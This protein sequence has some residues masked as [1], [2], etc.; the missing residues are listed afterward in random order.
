M[1]LLGQLWAVIV[2]SIVAAVLF[3]FNIRDVYPEWS[4]LYWAMVS[5]TC[6]QGVMTFGAAWFFLGGL[7]NVKPAQR[8]AYILLCIGV[9]AFGLSQAQL[10]FVAYAHA[11]WWLTNGFFTLPYLT[12]FVFFFLGMRQFA[13]VLGVKTRWV[14]WPVAFAASIG[15]AGIL[16]LIPRAAGA[17]TTQ[18]QYI[19]VVIFT[20]LVSVFFG[21]A[22]AAAFRLRRDAGRIYTK[23]LTWLAIGL[24]IGV[25]GGA[26]YVFVEMVVRT[27]WYYEGNITVL[28]MFT[29]SALTLYAGYAI[30]EINEI[31]SRYK[32]TR[33]SPDPL[34]FVEIVTYVSD[35]V[36]RPSEIDVVLDDLRATTAQLD[37]TQH[38]LDAAQEK[39]VVEVYHKIENYLVTRERVGMYTRES[40]RKNIIKQ[41]KLTKVEAETLWGE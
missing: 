18:E 23:A 34:V 26:H 33:I 12:S 38:N 6:A 24:G 25:I 32:P 29:S 7:G 14:S 40:L 9:V 19:T 21:F 20:T 1:S 41:F 17:P 27:P 30:R 28:F 4:T 39:S 15:A 22:A 11:Q 31:T 3:A 16:A 35:L 36:S 13:K 10:I 5:L 37:P 8:K 2:I